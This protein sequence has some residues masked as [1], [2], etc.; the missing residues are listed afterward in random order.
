MIER[1]PPPERIAG[2]RRRHLQ[3]QQRLFDTA[4]QPMAPIELA[5]ADQS[6][7]AEATT[8]VP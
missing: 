7:P 5:A 3:G 1:T 6:N 4:E 2:I 8:K